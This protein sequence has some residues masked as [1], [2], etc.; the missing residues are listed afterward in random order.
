MLNGTPLPFRSEWEKCEKHCG[1]GTR[2]RYRL[3]E[4]VQDQSKIAG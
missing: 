2:K 3:Y 1:V 4:S